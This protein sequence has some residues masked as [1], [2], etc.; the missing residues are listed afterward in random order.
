MKETR[1][2]F[3]PLF[4][5]NFFGVVNDNFLKTLASFVVIGWLPDEKMQ[6]VFMGLTAGALVLPYILFSP[7]ADRLTVVFEKK[8][9]FRLA[10]WAE[11]PIMAVAIAGFM[12]Q[13]A[14]LVVASVL[15]MG[16]QSS[17]YSPAKYALVRDVGGEGRISTGMGGM[18]GIAFAAVLAGTIAASFAADQ[19]APWVH[20]ACLGGFAALGLLFSYTI[21]AKEERSREI[22]SVN[23]IRYLRRARRM[24]GK[25]PGLNAVICTLSVFWWAAAMLQMGLLIYGKQVLGLDSTHTGGILALAAVGIVAGQVI[26]GF[27]DKHWFLLG[28]TLLTGWI[29][30]VLLLVLFLVPMGPT[31]FG[32]VIGVLA[33]DLGFYKLPFD[34]EI[35][36]VVKGPKLNTMLAYFNQVSFLFMLAASGCYALLSWLCGPRAFLLLLSVAF[37]IVPFAFIF[38]YRSVLCLTGRWIFSRRYAV[39]TVGLEALDPAKTYLVLPNHPAMV[40]PMLVTAELWRIPVKPLVD[41]LFLDRGGVSG[42]VLRTLGAVRV[43]D[44]RKSR[45]EAGAKIARG[46]TGVVTDALADGHNVIFYPSGHIW[47][48]EPKE[49]IGTRQLAYNVCRELPAGVEVVCVRT[50]GLWGSIWSRKGRKSSPNFASTLLRSI[51]LW[52][53]VLVTR[54]RRSVTMTFENLTTQVKD[55]ASACTRLEFNRKLEEWYNK[56]SYL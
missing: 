18:E 34:A 32:I 37:F 16:L 50:E 3:L 13:S 15:L 27:V 51:L 10:K 41:E 6:S 38:N 26:A 9:I 55:W 49:E 53:V 52:L 45:S 24:A 44:L 1:N 8:K 14:A 30:A 7:L 56:Y 31:A 54:R 23:P 22:H 28:A 12:L 35:Q 39:K 29:A 11:L 47:T 4:V 36:K 19:A 21:R 48:T 40:D 46:L 25:F 42:K 2:S 43:P 5:T 17:L 33:F 20:Y